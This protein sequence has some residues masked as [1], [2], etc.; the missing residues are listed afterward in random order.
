MT[1][2][3]PNAPKDFWNKRYSAADYAYGTEPNQFFKD[4]LLNL[5]LNGK[6]L[7][8]AE[9]EGRNA[10]FAAKQGL[11]VTAF[12]TSKEGK[13]KAEKFAEVNG[14]NINYFVGYF[15]EL[16]FELESFDIIGLFFAHFPSNLKLK[17]HKKNYQLIKD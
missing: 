13:K 15:D 9:G 4:S 17:Y 16:K 11:D 14:V 10:V 1:T 3:E 12:D 6:I 8:P 5:K 2:T 7:L